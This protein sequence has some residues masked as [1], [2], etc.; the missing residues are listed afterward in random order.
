MFFWT[1]LI[2][3]LW[4]ILENPNYSSWRWIP[5]KLI[6]ADEAT[7][8]KSI[9]CRWLY[10]PEFLYEIMRSCLNEE[11]SLCKVQEEMKKEFI[12]ISVRVNMSSSLPD[13]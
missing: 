2:I 5:T 4:I 1:D 8:D 3:V 6:A 10:G 7:R 9:K 12:G 11:L 13:I